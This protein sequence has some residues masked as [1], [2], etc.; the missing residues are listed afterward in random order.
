[1]EDDCIRDKEERYQASGIKRDLIRQVKRE[2]LE[3]RCRT[4]KSKEERADEIGDSDGENKFDSA[5]RDFLASV[6]EPLPP[7]GEEAR[8]EY[9]ARGGGPRHAQ[10]DLCDVADGGALQGAPA[11]DHRP[12]P[13]GHGRLV[14]PD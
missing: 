9:W 5:I 14:L 10:D 8:S 11:G 13:W 6:P 1:M 12:A 4:R 3:G 2:Q 7:G